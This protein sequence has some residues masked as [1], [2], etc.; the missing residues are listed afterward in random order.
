MKYSHLTVSDHFSGLGGWSWAAQQ[1]LKMRLIYAINHWPVAINLYK[2]N[3]REVLTYLTDICHRDPASVPGSDVLC[4]SPECTNYTN[5]LGIAV[6]D[7]LQPPLWEAYVEAWR[8]QLSRA[9]SRALIHQVPRFAKEHGYK[10]IF[11]E[12][13]TDIGDDREFPALIDEM[14]GNKEKKIVGLGY[15]VRQI[16]LNSMFFG[17]SCSRD[18]AYLI[19]AREDVDL[20][21]TD[22]A[23]SAYCARC[24]SVQTT[25]QDWGKQA[26]RRWRWGDY[27]V[28]YWYR[29]VQCD[30]IVLPPTRP[31]SEALDLSLPMNPVSKSQ[32]RS[33]KIKADIA[34]GIKKFHG[35]PFIRTY[36][37]TAI[38]ATLDRPAPTIT[39]KARLALSIP[40]GP[41]VEDCL[42]RMVSPG[43]LKKMMTFPDEYLIEGTVEDQIKLIGNAVTPLP[44]A[45]LMDHYLAP[46]AVVA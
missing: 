23:P 6:E 35:K 11:F 14:C 29:C 25:W 5:A 41:H 19:F 44:M 34:T 13:V 28:Q 20:P 32:I 3:F 46:L 1:L 30:E 18:R 4:T 7:R 40:Q 33:E 15:K 43:E 2:Q 17:A 12:N 22:L 38:F 16:C 26:S 39:T 37:R 8:Q 24:R 36:N 21:E 10:I 42:H 27:G 45:A 31:A 9:Q